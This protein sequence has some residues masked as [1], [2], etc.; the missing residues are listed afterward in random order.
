VG[1][2]YLLPHRNPDVRPRPIRDARRKLGNVP[3]SVIIEI[4]VPRLLP[5]LVARL[6]AA[7]CSA[8]PISSHACRV[9]HLQAESM[10]VAVLELR[11]FAKAWAGAHGDV[12][13]QV[14]PA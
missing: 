13:V 5:Q 8:V 11:F 12:A 6:R 14:R 4:D 1:Q 3:L 2:N 7:D 10:S 9:V